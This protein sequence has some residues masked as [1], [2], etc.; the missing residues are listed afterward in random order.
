MHI[1]LTAKLENALVLTDH[2][3]EAYSAALLRTGSNGKSNGYAV[4]QIL[5]VRAITP[6]D[7]YVNTCR[8]G[9]V[10]E[11]GTERTSCE[12]QEEDEKEYSLSFAI[13]AFRNMFHTLT[14]LGWSD[15]FDQPVKGKYNFI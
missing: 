13:R 3:G 15:R 9:L 2:A 5:T 8:V 4:I 11:P 12:V 10:G 1:S 14:G 7:C 6:T